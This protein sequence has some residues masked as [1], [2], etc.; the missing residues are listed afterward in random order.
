MW[1]CIQVS[2][3]SS[4]TLEYCFQ[5]GIKCF[6]RAEQFSDSTY[7]KW[8]HSI[9]LRNSN[10]IMPLTLYLKSPW[11]FNSLLLFPFVFCF[12]KLSYN[13][14]TPPRRS[15]DGFVSGPLSVQA[16]NDLW[17]CYHRLETSSWLPFSPN[18][19]KLFNRSYK[20]SHL[21]VPIISTAP[22]S[23]GHPERA[24]LGSISSCTT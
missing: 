24:C 18:K 13:H 2:Q 15:S 19:G 11:N 20:Q 3:E 9:S 7:I 1:V 16:D 17:P 12:C 5:E 21:H 23:A 22:W 6:P 14:C 8:I 10:Y 4:Q